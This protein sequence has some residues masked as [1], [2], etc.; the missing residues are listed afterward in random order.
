LEGVEED[1][2]RNGV[3]LNADCDQGD[4][5]EFPTDRKVRLAPLAA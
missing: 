5:D 4:A 2:D 1:G 3:K